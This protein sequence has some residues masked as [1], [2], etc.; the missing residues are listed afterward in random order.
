MRFKQHRVNAIQ[1]EPHL[2]SEGGFWR[3]GTRID[4]VQFWLRNELLDVLGVIESPGD[5]LDE[6]RT[7]HHQA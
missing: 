2:S 3:D 6:S 5:G 1:V 7:Y 4:E